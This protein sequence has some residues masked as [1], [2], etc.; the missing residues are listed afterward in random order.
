M[1]SPAEARRRPALV[2][3]AKA[4]G[5]RLAEGQAGAYRYHVLLAT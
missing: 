4:I 1:E 2:S 5:P 3:L